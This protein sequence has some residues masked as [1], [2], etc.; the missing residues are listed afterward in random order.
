M[1]ESGDLKKE[2][3]RPLVI[4]LALAELIERLSLEEKRIL[5][6]LLDWDILQQLREEAISQTRQVGDPRIYVGTTESGLS[7]E[8]PLEYV[9]AFLSALP[10]L[11]SV[12]HVEI[13]VQNSQETEEYRCAAADLK[14]WLTRHPEAWQEKAMMIELGPHTLI[15]GGG[16][17]LSLALE[18]VP[19]A[20]RQEIAQMMLQL[21]G[22]DHT[23]TRDHFSAIVWENQLEVTE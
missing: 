22:Y 9:L 15:S 1:R 2:E 19:S 17:C 23:F 6:D 4:P 3:W 21:C 11:L 10:S 5:V 16:G 18:N 13:L 20:V 12:Q 8:L 7:L 14:N